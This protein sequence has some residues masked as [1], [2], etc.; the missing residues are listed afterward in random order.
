[1][2][3]QYLIYAENET[4]SKAATNRYWDTTGTNRKLLHTKVWQTHHG[5]T[6]SA[7]P[8]ANT[9]SEQTT[10]SNTSNSPQERAYKRVNRITIRVKRSLLQARGES[11]RPAR[12]CLKK[13]KRRNR[14]RRG[15]RGL[16][17]SCTALANTPTKGA[18]RVFLRVADWL[19]PCTRCGRRAAAKPARQSALATHLTHGET[20]TKSTIGGGKINGYIQQV[21]YNS[22]I[23]PIV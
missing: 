12:I 14:L 22:K 20:P 2:Q 7:R 4:S 13:K 15:A 19:T 8:I 21:I 9:Y 10:D 16:L 17:S 3:V 5:G 6:C 18:I 11:A 23:L 1:M